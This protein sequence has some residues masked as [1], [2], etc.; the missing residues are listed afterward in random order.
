MKSEFLI[1]ISFV[2]ICMGEICVHKTGRDSHFPME[3]WNVGGDWVQFSFLFILPDQRFYIVKNVCVRAC[4]CVCVCI[5][6][7]IHTHTH[8][9]LPA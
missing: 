1:L 2:I 3:M 7:Y 5:Y 8:I 4:V 9:I 6:I